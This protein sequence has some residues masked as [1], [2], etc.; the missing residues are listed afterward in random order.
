MAEALDRYVAKVMAVYADR[1]AL[2]QELASIYRTA[3]RDGVSP[4][5][6]KAK[7]Q[8]KQRKAASEPDKPLD[9]HGGFV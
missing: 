5:V 7:I 4:S 2:T 8:E 1:E 3:R 6:I 9:D